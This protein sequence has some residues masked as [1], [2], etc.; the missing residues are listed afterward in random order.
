MYTSDGSLRMWETATGKEI[1]PP[2]PHQSSAV[3]CLSPDAKRL[4]TFGREQNLCEWDVGTATEVRRLSVQPLERHYWQ[5]GQIALSPDGTILAVS[6]WRQ[7]NNR[8]VGA[9]KLWDATSGQELRLLQPHKDWVTAISFSPD[10]K[11]LAVACQDEAA[12]IWE[13][14]TGKLLRRCPCPTFQIGDRKYPARV[15]SLA[16]SPDGKL[17]A[18]GNH[19]GTV[20]LWDPTDDKVLRSWRIQGGSRNLAFSPDGKLLASLGGKANE[21]TV[22]LSDPATG[23]EIRQIGPYPMLDTLAFSPDGQL[24]AVGTGEY[25]GLPS[26]RLIEVST[27]QEC[28]QLHGHVQSATTL[29]FGPRGRTLL[30]AGA[31]STAVL[32]DTTGLVGRLTG[33]PLPAEELNA[34][35]AD[36]AGAD[37]AK[38]FDAI[39][40]LAAFPDQAVPYLRERVKSV[41]TP[42]AAKVKQWIA[43]LESTDFE[44]RRK[45]TGELEQL[46]ELVERELREAL[47]AKPSLDK[48]QRLELLVQRLERKRLT[49]TGDTLRL[50]RAVRVLQQAGT[51]EACQLLAKLAEGAPS[52][53]V[54]VEARAA[55]QQLTDR[56]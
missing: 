56:P 41:A 3:A 46:E 55:I 53:R 10:G 35:W 31:D 1:G 2:T 12:D 7:E 24:L 36:L 23:K 5:A 15:Y 39:C 13:V 17:L 19:D 14:A 22:C 47:A 44:V 32:W 45:A 28:R 4:F 34:R 8:P 25:R 43:D 9:V 16:Y 18:G 49:P 52:A 21:A 37:A 26:L 6:G 40:A 38:A 20:F 54:T 11:A 33:R 30:S 48:Q 27:G 29:A 51:A 42:D 50:L